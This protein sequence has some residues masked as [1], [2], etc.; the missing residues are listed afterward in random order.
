M[1]RLYSFRIFLALLLP[2]FFFLSA[3]DSGGS[4]E[5]EELNNEFSFTVT[6]TSSSDTEAAV[7]KISQRDINGF[8][9][10]VD[11]DDIEEVDEQAFVVYF[12][13]SDTFSQQNATQGLF[14]FVGRKSSQPG[15]G[16][17]TLVDAYEQTDPA[18]AFVGFLYEDFQNIGTANS[19]PY[20]IIRSGT[21]T[22]TESSDNEVSG[23]ITANAT[24]F[25]ISGDQYTEERVEITGEFS[26]ENLDSYVPFGEYTTTPGQ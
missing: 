2:A 9:F 26:A 24:A 1:K 13:G 23:S 5:E 22:V 11:T 20:Y 18:S 12:S 19:L 17:Y 21:L 25:T 15:N 7:P 6:P 10:F 16:D 4:N 8:S 14:G 3:C